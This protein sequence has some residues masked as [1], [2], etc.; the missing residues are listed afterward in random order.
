MAEAGR[1][2]TTLGR[3]RHQMGPARASYMLSTHLG[4]L[5][6]GTPTSSGE[7]GKGTYP[8][9]RVPLA[10]A[11]STTGRTRAAVCTEKQVSESLCR[12]ACVG[13]Q[14]TCE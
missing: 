12:R 11:W 2:G 6:P 7:G 4:G 1:N 3:C 10:A 14:S 5:V 8:W 13:V 9:L